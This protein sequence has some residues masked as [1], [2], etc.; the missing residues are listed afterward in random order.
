MC[1]IGKRNVK[2]VVRYWVDLVGMERVGG[3]WKGLGKISEC[4]SL[5][6]VF[7]LDCIF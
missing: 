3:L 1:F 7:L 4:K 6:R 2:G 5:K